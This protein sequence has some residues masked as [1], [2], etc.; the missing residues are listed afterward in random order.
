MQVRNILA[1]F[2]I[3]NAA[4]LA[5]RVSGLQEPICPENDALR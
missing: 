1:W 3:K 4:K 5:K 2:A